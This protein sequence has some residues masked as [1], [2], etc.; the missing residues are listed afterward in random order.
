MMETGT[1][2]FFAAKRYP[3]SFA[4]KRGLSPFPTLWSPGL[5]EKDPED[6][7]TRGMPQLPQRLGFDLPN[8]LPRDREVLTDF[9]QS[10]LATVSDAEPQLENLFLAGRQCLQDRLSLGP[11]VQLNR[12]LDRG[13]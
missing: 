8:P 3:R 2:P 5:F 7:A 11:Q 10:V 9:F 4:R 6:F 13:D 1:V 12:C